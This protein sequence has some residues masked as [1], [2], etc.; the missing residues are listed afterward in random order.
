MKKI[1]IVILLTAVCS[2][3]FAQKQKWRQFGLKIETNFTLERNYAN[4][5][6]TL[7]GLVNPDAYLFFRGGKFIYGEIGFGYNFFKGDFS[8]L[9]PDGITYAFQNETV[10]LHSLMIPIK[11]MGYIP[12]GKVVA[13]EPYVGVIYQPLI[14][15]SNNSIDFSK[16][17]LEQNM[18]F[19][20]AGL[21]FKFG[22]I[23]IGASY[24]YGLNTFFAS[25]EGKKP[26]FV[27]VCVGF[28]F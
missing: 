4:D 18:L 26:Q 6:T 10:K 25:K 1:L 21:D 22:P 11:L 15:I 20:N 7:D 17:T 2:T 12:L 16:K 23:V 8:R 28:Q 24:K 5:G 3:T 14:S 27:N 19:A 13:I 9:N